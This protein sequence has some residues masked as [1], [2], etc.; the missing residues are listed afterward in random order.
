MDLSADFVDVIARF[1]GFVADSVGF[2]DFKT[3][4]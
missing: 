3:F 2:V 4:S 1:L